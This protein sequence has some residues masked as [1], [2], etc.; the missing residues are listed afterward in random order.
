M[1]IMLATNIILAAAIFVAVVGPLIWAIRT[2]ARDG[3]ATPSIAGAAPA[4]TSRPADRRP[5]PRTAAPT[6]SS[7]REVADS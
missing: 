3:V 5:R 1:T 2:Q 6:L 7:P 4:K